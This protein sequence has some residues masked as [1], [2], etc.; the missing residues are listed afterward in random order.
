VQPS[1]PAIAR[2]FRAILVVAA[3]LALALASAVP[4]PARADRH[5]PEPVLAAAELVRPALLSGPE[6]RVQPQAQLVG[7]MASFTLDTGSGPIRADSVELLE[8]RAAEMAAIQV[9][10]AVAGHEAFGLAA[11]GRVKD[12]GATLARVVVQPLATVAGMPAGVLRYFAGELDKWSGRLRRH[13]DRIGERAGNAGDPYAMVGPM[14][15]GRDG[16]PGKAKRRWYGKLGRELGRQAEDAVSHGSARRALAR[17]L[18]IDPYAATSNPALNERLDRL[19]WAAAAG[20]MSVSELVGYLPTG[21][22]TALDHG[23]RVDALVWELD[24]EDLRERNRAV[25]SRWCG[26][27]FQIRRFVRNGAFLASVQTR[28]ASAVDA[29]G[30]GAGCEHLLD[31]AL[32]AGHEVEARFLANGLAM[33]GDFLGPAARGSQI[34]PVGAGLVLLLPDGRKVLP[35]PVDRLSWTALA[36]EF[37]ALPELA[38]GPRS[39]LVGGDVSERA[40]R[41][42]TALGWEIVVRTPYAGAPAYAHACCA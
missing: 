16:R 13:G 26:D 33:A 3:A 19:A 22:R 18:G 8:V 6:F 9:L 32:A 40:L 28:L 11:L 31:L 34:V 7:F 38:D 12:T 23:G 4:R 41:E 36:E 30:P 14:N 24:P 5:E 15:A 17:E 27:G 37:F 1:A 29:I 10:D 21:A 39:V 20:S 25:L 42:L 2:R 35:L